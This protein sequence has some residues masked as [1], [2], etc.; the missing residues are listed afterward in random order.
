MIVEL[1]NN[2]RFPN[3]LTHKRNKTLTTKL[4]K[5]QMV[6]V[7]LASI[8]IPWA[9]TIWMMYGLQTIIPLNSLK[10][11]NRMTKTSGFIVRL[12]FNSLALSKNVA[13][14]WSHAIDCLAH[15]AQAFAKALCFWSRVNSSCTAS[16]PTQPRSH[17]NAFRAP[18]GRSF[19]SNQFGDSGI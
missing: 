19:E 17:C 13:F 4:I 16:G 2:F 1:I 15:E 7:K 8:G 10:T 11:Y 12:Y 18:F 3:V 9:L 14:G 6:A 5:L